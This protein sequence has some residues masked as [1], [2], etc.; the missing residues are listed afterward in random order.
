[1]KSSLKII[2]L[3][4]FF[5]FF[6]ISS[7]HYNKNIIQED[8]RLPKK[9]EVGEE[10]DYVVKYSVMRLGEIKLRITDKKNI[11]GKTSYSAIA[12]IDSYPSIP[13]VNLHQVYETTMTPDYYSKYFKGIIKHSDYTSYSEYHFNYSDSLVSIKEGKINDNSSSYDTTIGID[14]KYQ[15]G[16]SI[17]Y[18]ARMNSG[19]DKEVSIP[20]FIDKKKVSTDITFEDK[21]EDVSIDAVDYDVDCVHLEGEAHF[22]SIF[23]LTGDFEGWFSNDEAAI[24]IK[25]RMKV[26]LGNI[27]LEL[28][29]WKRTG[30]NPPRY[31]D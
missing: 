25:A 21:S 19:Q 6:L 2:I 1:M 28:K 26:L 3:L 20:T 16:L 12:D 18:Y 15:D 27:T 5:T 9:L 23:G 31:K 29:S 22:I 13:F 11:N 30:W 7:K 8:S 17:F 10:L 24:P 14:K 4:P